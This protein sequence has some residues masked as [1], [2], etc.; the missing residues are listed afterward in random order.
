MRQGTRTRSV[1][2]FLG[3]ILIAFQLAVGC[4][5][6]TGPNSPAPNNNP[7]GRAIPMILEVHAPPDNLPREISR[8]PDPGLIE[9]T[10]RSLPWSDI[11]F[12]V[13]KIDDKNWIEGSGSLNP[14]DGLS[15]SY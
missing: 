8:S 14:E 11:T 10:V 5:D 3:P 12:V 4:S 1:P 7:P 15:A 13:L 6:R 9:K 2:I